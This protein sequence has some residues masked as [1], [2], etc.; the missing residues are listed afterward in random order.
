MAHALTT[1]EDGRVEFAF[2]GD[3]KAI[4]HTL[5]T[6][7]DGL[8]H[9]EEMEKKSGL[10]W[11]AIKVPLQYEH[12]G[13]MYYSSQVAIV[14]DDN[15]RQLGV[16]S[17]NFTTIQNNECFEIGTNLVQSGEA[18]WDTAGSI[19]GGEIVFMS[20]KLPSEYLIHSK[21]DNDKVEKYLL[22]TNCFSGKKALKALVTPQRVVCQNTLNVALGKFDA[23]FSIRHTKNAKNRIEEGKRV[24]GLASQ[25]YDELH[26]VLNNLAFE[27]ISNSY[28]EEFISTVFP[29]NKEEVSTR[30]ENNRAI[31]MSLFKNGTGTFGE[32]KGDMFNAITEYADW[33]QGGR[34]TQKALD[35]ADAF[36]DIEGEQ[37][38]FRSLMGN[39]A[40]LK[41]KAFDLLTA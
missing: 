20:M 34:I 35:N 10:S 18:L 2:S 15:S 14:R 19:L 17:D 31:V 33:V 22:I 41:Q 28:A 24:L 32:T 11:K 36:T 30:T 16:V 23:Q 5:G 25:Y 8:Q 37:R 12:N 7:V 13:K 29:N 1:H 4:W 38:F 3:R 40:A 21:Q 27:E 26:K 9:G 39:G 6:Q